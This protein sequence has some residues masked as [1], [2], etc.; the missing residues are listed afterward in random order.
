VTAVLHGR[1]AIV[2]GASR[3]VGRAVAQRLAAR[4]ASVALA[5]RT[6]RAQ[7]RLPGTIHEVADEIRATGGTAIAMPCDVADQDSVVALVEAAR[8][9]FGPVDILVNNAALTVPDR[10]PR[11][12]SDPPR[13]PMRDALSILNFPVA[14]YRRAFEVNLFGVYALTQLVLPDMVGLGR[15]HIVNVSSDAAHEPG[16]GPYADAPG[17]PLHA[18][19]TSKAALEQ[20]T[21]TVAYEMSRHGIAV[22]AALPSLPVAT[23]GTA[24]AGGADL[25]ATLAMDRP[26][27]RPAVTPR[28]TA[29]PAGTAVPCRTR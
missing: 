3:G 14:A 22:N 21:R 2:T 11:S 27:A 4:G 15:G 18:Y 25:G 28:R 7:A 6:E 16:E 19:G 12:D 29:R 8:A 26:S 17:V 1:V 24:F 10:R 9:R 20:L 5:A 13:L 23:P